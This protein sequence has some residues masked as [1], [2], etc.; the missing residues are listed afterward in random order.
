MTLVCFLLG[1]WYSLKT[2]NPWTALG[3]LPVEGHDYTGEPPA[4]L[5]CDRCGHIERE[6]SDER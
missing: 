2:F 6:A 1:V 3:W 5:V 4:D